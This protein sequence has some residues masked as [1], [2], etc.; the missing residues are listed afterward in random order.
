[1]TTT[2]VLVGTTKGVFLIR[3]DDRAEWTLRGPLCDGWPINHVVGDPDTGMLWAAGGGEFWGAGV[4]RS[5]DGG[6]TWTLSKLANGMM[7][8]MLADSQEMRDYLKMEPSPPAPF[9]G[10]VEALWSLGAVRGAD[11]CRRQARR[12]VRQ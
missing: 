4:W 12:P 6:E 3:S 8:T 9:T 7:D 11:L 1:M 5:D 10:E 2:T